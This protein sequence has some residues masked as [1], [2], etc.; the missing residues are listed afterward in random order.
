MGYTHYWKIKKKPELKDLS[1][2]L[3]NIKKV[4][5]KYMDIIQYEEDEAKEPIAEKNLIRFNGIGEDG[6]ETFL[7]EFPI[8]K[9][10]L[11]YQKKQGLDDDKDYSFFFCKTARKPYDKA[12]T[13]CLLILKEYLKSDMVLESDGSFSDYEE[14]GEAIEEVNNMG[15]NIKMYLMAEEL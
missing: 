6:H 14:W 7:F 12:V 4:I 13:R 8:S 1:G 5:A 2:C 9:E 11:E 10:T 15:I 3:E